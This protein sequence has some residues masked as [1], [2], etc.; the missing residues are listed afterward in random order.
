MNKLRDFTLYGMTLSTKLL[1]KNILK[2]FEFSNGLWST[3]DH[4]RKKLIFTH[5]KF[6]GFMACHDMPLNII[7]L[8]VISV[9]IYLSFGSMVSSCRNDLIKR[10]PSNKSP[11]SNKR[12][13]LSA[14][15]DKRPYSKAQV[16]V[17]KK[18]NSCIF[19]MSH[20]I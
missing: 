16:K 19:F 6:Y 20:S 9:L 15:F 17:K 13:Q 3:L 14:F 7:N 4:K 12:F 2:Y 1:E 18:V 8:K 5:C 11:L 10:C